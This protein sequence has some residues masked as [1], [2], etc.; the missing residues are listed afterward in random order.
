MVKRT[1]LLIGAAIA[2]VAVSAGSFGAVKYVSAQSPENVLYAALASKAPDTMY[3]KESIVKSEGSD[4]QAT[5]M[6]NKD[7]VSKGEGKLVCSA[8]SDE[9]GQTSLDLT[10]RQI[11]EKVYL[12]I[13]KM[14]VSGTGDESMESM[15]NELGRDMYAGKWIASDDLKSAEAFKEKRISFD[16][17][18]ATAYN[19]GGR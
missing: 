14:T 6:I 3:G 5:F 16:S 11:N 18:G 9:S 8:S 12:R 2:V 4:L 7:G 1:K 19:C 15:V 17:L 13:D 10:M